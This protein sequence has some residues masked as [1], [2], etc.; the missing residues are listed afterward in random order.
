M[1]YGKNFMN[2]FHNFFLRSM[3]KC[4]LKTTFL[5]YRVKKY[6]FTL[7]MDTIFPQ[8]F[9]INISS[10]FPSNVSKIF[11]DFFRNCSTIYSDFFLQFFPYFYYIWKVNK[12]QTLGCA[13]YIAIIWSPRQ[14]CNEWR[15]NFPGSFVSLTD[16]PLRCCSLQRPH[17]ESLIKF[18][19]PWYI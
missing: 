15:S 17:A 18:W 13:F 6:H 12:N 8:F 9:S 14:H 11:H 4:W 3:E 7:E 2:Y 10:I 5:P 1:N 19:T 16:D